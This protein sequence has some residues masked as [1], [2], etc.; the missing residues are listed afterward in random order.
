MESAVVS[1]SVPS[2]ICVSP[3]H[4]GL[5]QFKI[6]NLS[7]GSG[8]N[9]TWLLINTTSCFTLPFHSTEIRISRSNWGTVFLC[10]GQWPGCYSHVAKAISAT[11]RQQCY[12]VSYIPYITQ[13]NIPILTVVVSQTQASSLGA[14]TQPNCTISTMFI[15]VT[16]MTDVAWL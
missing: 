16:M 14:F 4:R 8:S 3:N 11:Q 12:V 7:T 10:F 9:K 2:L 6:S 5:R 1:E 15:I 13:I